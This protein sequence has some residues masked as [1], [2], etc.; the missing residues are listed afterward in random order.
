MSSF[1]RCIVKLRKLLYIHFSMFTAGCQ[2]FFPMFSQGSDL[3]EVTVA[4]CCLI[5]T[6]SFVAPFCPM[7][8]N[9]LYYYCYCFFTLAECYL[10]YFMVRETHKLY[11]C[12]QLDSIKILPHRM[13]QDSKRSR[14]SISKLH[15]MPVSLKRSWLTVTKHWNPFCFAYRETSALIGGLV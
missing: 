14:L 5:D 6:V 11:F 2:E 3:F 8:S 13:P 15:R 9:H 4:F 10:F 12:C 7:K 1:S